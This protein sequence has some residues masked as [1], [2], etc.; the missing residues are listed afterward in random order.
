MSQFNSVLKETIDAEYFDEARKI[1]RD[2][3]PEANAETYYLASLVSEEE[4]QKI[5]YLEKALE[6]DPLHSKAYK[7]KKELT[8]QPEARATSSPPTPNDTM[9]EEKAKTEQATKNAWGVTIT[10][11]PEPTPAKVSVEPAKP[12][13]QPVRPAPKPAGQPISATSTPKQKVYQNSEKAWKNAVNNSDFELSPKEKALEKFRG[14]FKNSLIFF[15]LAGVVAGIYDSTAGS[16]ELSMLAVVIFVAFLWMIIMIVQYIS[17]YMRHGNASEK[18]KAATAAVGLAAIVLAIL[19]GVSATSNTSST[20]TTS[21][22]AKSSFTPTYAKSTSKLKTKTSST[23]TCPTC[24][25]QGNI[26]QQTAS[27]CTS[28]GGSGTKEERVPDGGYS[29]NY[30]ESMGFMKT[31][32]INCTR[33]NGSGK[34][35]KSTTKQCPTCQGRR[36]VRA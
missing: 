32:R 15:I 35:H 21:S 34:N 26:A 25:G 12:A 27:R 4:G 31:V 5:E 19:K 9:T 8:A 13:P 17:I 2:A 23:K 1:L 29:K 33:C 14:F 18:Q 16:D 6:L 24:R 30:A 20:R 7:A 22:T 3:L 10:P 36:T 28:C 11:E